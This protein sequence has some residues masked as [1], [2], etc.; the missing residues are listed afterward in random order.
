M[1]AVALLELAGARLAA[2]VMATVGAGEAVGQASLREG[3]EALVFGA[4]EIG[5]RSSG[6]LSGTALGCVPLKIHY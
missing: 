6:C 3:V 1:A 5:I 4:V 2:A